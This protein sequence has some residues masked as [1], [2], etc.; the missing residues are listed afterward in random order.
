MYKFIL[1]LCF[2]SVGCP[3]VVAVSVCGNALLEAGETCDD[4]NTTNADGCEANCTLPACNNGI[5][6]PGELCLFDPL[7]LDTDPGPTDLVAADLNNDGILDLATSTES[8]SIN[9][10][11]GNGVGGLSPFFTI[12]LDDFAL[13][14]IVVDV[15]GDGFLDLATTVEQAEAVEIFQGLG[16]GS[17]APFATLSAVAPLDIV[18]GDFSENG[19]LDLVVANGEAI[20]VHLNNGVGG[21][22][23]PRSFLAGDTV[24]ELVQGDFNGDDNLDVVALENNV[25]AFVLFLGDGLGNFVV[26]TPKP[27]G[28]SPNDL[29][30]Q[31]L[32]GDSVL[33]LALSLAL[34]EVAIFAGNGDG[35]FAAPNKFSVLNP[36]DLVFGDLDGDGLLDLALSHADPNLNADLVI[37]LG[38]GK[39][40][41]SP[42]P[43]FFPLG[44][45]GAEELILDDLNADGALDV[46]LIDQANQ[47][48]V[49]L[50]EP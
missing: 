23:A 30:A 5:V 2:L 35:L 36:A 1:A 9:V 43:L 44:V 10:F 42:E 8:N 40:V 49:F 21:F 14:L 24:F 39:G 32:D 34:S 38:E 29:L 17:F 45:A 18:A 46:A 13:D 26:Q 22:L 50:S 15:D 3:G 6:D 31:D 33:D 11:L 4:T 41:F 19:A 16:D 27:T 47:V 25:N 37:Q 48:F 20:D 28:I 7:I 12:A